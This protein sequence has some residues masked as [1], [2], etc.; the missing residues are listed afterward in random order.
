VGIAADVKQTGLDEARPETVYVPLR[1][2]PYWPAFSFVIRTSGDPESMASAVRRQIRELDPMVPA[3]NIRTMEEVLARSM[4]PARSSMML[5]ALFAGVALLEALVGVFG[6]LSYTVSQR[7]TE[8]GIRMALGAAAG[9]VVRL[10]LA[11]GMRP[12]LAGIALGLAGAVALSRYLQ[13]LLYGV[14]PMDPATFVAAPLAMTAVA[15]AASYLAAR[16][17]TRVDP[18]AALRSE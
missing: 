8:M 17:A 16:R 7:T 9:D 13:S 4:A 14:G 5:L 12:V 18:L 2:M 6:V 10:V 11:G 1:V 3:S 15:G